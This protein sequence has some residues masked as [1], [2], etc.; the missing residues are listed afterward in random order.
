LSASAD[1][2]FVM[3]NTYDTTGLVTNKVYADGKW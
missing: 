1:F 2:I 3:S